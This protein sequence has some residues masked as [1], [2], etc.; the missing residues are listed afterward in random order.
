MKLRD[1]LTEDI[2]FKSEVGAVHVKINYVP[3]HEAMFAKLGLRPTINDAYVVYAHTLDYSQHDTMDLLKS[4]KKYA[5]GGAAHE[6]ELTNIVDNAIRAVQR[7]EPNMKGKHESTK[8]AVRLLQ[9]MM[10][11]GKRVVVVPAPSSSTFSKF[12]AQR[13]ATQI[14]ATLID[15]LEKETHPPISKQKL[16]KEYPDEDFSN[17]EDPSMFKSTM[18]AAQA[19]ME[20]AI[21]ADDTK[22]FEYWEKE[23]EKARK[24]YETYVYKRKSYQYPYNAHIGKAFYNTVKTK[25]DVSKLQ[26]AFV[27]IVDDNVMQGV[28]FAEAIKALL[29][30][31]VVPKQIVG[32]VPHRF[33][34]S[35]P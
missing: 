1:I 5:D 21:E 2:D 18:T 10:A 11:N 32:F 4:R 19:R 8:A 12:I 9:A 15:V 27:I 29:L 28:T 17:V 30:Q 14:G 24:K 31:G 23:Y 35:R 34:S 16:Q 22:M 26:G 7:A 33:T 6:A 13:L 20:Q 3:E 25:A